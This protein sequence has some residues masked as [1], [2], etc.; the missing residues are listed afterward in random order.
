M[1][2]CTYILTPINTYM[3]TVRDVRKSSPLVDIVRKMNAYIH[4]REQSA[5]YSPEEGCVCADGRFITEE[6][7]HEV[8]IRLLNTRRLC[9]I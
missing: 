5:L 2:T 8:T 6:E 4:D 7:I 3:R 9:K 1:H